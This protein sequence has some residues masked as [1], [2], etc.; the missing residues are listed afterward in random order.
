MTPKQLKTIVNKVKALYEQV[1][2]SRDENLDDVN[3]SLRLSPGIPQ[4]K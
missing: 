3:I 4:A 2:K 1:Y